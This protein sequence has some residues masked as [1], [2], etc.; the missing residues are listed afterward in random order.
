MKG[1]SMCG[2]APVYGRDGTIW[3][4]DRAPRIYLEDRFHA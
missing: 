2:F 4:L 1:D 3:Y